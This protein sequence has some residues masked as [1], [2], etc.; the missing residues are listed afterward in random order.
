MA[1]V[2]GFRVHL[3]RNEYSYGKYEYE[4]MGEVNLYMQYWDKP[5]GTQE[6][7]IIAPETAEE[8]W[9][10]YSD[11]D[12]AVGS[13]EFSAEEYCMTILDGPA[14]K[15]EEIRNWRRPPRRR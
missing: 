7:T 2:P 14:D 13:L 9:A 15:L 6:L 10:E 8:C 1:S 11:V 4:F 12:H 3:T 5:D